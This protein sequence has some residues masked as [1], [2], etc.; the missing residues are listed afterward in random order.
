MKVLEEFFKNYEVFEINKW[1]AERVFEELS[2]TNENKYTPLHYVAD[3][4]YPVDKAVALIKVFLQLGVDPNKMES[5]GGYSF[6][7]LALY[8][9]YELD[10]FKKVLPI[11]IW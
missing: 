10:F 1:T 11:A 5:N 8:S 4:P 2:K 3:K 9:E 7:H 6:V